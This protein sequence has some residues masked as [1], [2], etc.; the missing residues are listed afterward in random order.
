MDVH[1]DVYHAIDL[2]KMLQ[3][4]PGVDLEF[5]NNLSHLNVGVFSLVL[6][7]KFIGISPGI[8]YRI[9]SGNYSCWI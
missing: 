8:M 3:K 9:K 6:D 2:L 7:V 5:A 1:V 4:N